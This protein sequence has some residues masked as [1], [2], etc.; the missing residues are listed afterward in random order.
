[1]FRPCNMDTGIPRGGWVSGSTPL[2]SSF[3]RSLLQHPMV[4]ISTAIHNLPRTKLGRV[5]EI[6]ERCRHTERHGT[7]SGA[8]A[9]S[10]SATH[11]SHLAPTIS[12]TALPVT[13]QHVREHTKTHE[14]IEVCCKCI[15]YPQ[16]LAPSFSVA[17][18]VQAV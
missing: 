3:P 12:C 4:A 1:M 9:S 8:S 5:I 6:L 2:G 16:P 11:A 14:C 10:S 18:A 13:P 17:A 7:H 15:L